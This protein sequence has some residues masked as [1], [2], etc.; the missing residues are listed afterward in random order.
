MT[1]SAS[2]SNT[3]KVLRRARLLSGSVLFLNVLLNVANCSATA[4]RLAEVS[5]II[6]RKYSSRSYR[7]N[8]VA[9]DTLHS[10][11]QECHIVA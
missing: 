9:L 7:G 8:R 1:L 5:L 6:L 4:W 2:A 11:P 3:R 10:L